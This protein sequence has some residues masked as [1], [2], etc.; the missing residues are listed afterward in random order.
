MN[1]PELGYQYLNTAFT[2]T[3]NPA[4]S[5]NVFFPFVGLDFG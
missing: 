1:E 4:L 3:I 5:G 2:G